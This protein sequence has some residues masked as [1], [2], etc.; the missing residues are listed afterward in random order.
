MKLPLL[1][2]SLVLLSSSTIFGME[3]L[4]KAMQQCNMRETEQQLSVKHL[5]KHPVLLCDTAKA[6]PCQ[7]Q[8]LVLFHQIWHTKHPSEGPR[9]RFFSHHYNGQ[10]KPGDNPF[11]NGL[12][13]KTIQ[14]LTHMED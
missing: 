10:K 1:V 9:A 5:K 4:L 6:S 11:L 3:E 2:V 14:T 12:T 7:A 8:M 13:F